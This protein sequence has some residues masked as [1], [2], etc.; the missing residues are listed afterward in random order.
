[1]LIERGFEREMLGGV[2]GGVP[3]RMVLK[4]ARPKGSLPS[5]S[6][7]GHN[8]T[9]PA[10]VLAATVGRT[11]LVGLGSDWISRKLAQDF[12]GKF[13]NI[14][15]IMDCVTCESCKMH[16]RNIRTVPYPPH[17]AT[18][19]VHMFHAAWLNV[20]RTLHAAPRSA[21]ACTAVAG[22]QAKLKAQAIGTALK[23]TLPCTRRSFVTSRVNV[24]AAEHGGYAYLCCPGQRRGRMV[25]VARCSLPFCQSD[26]RC[27]AVLRFFST[28]RTR[29]FRSKG[30]KSSP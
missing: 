14:S 3:K 30:M 19:T 6:Q 26:W 17:A 7:R 24:G 2:Q 28:R 13:N 25:S 4:Q 20:L 10:R 29:R 15:R 5:A 12:R 16:V 22:L 1:V 8:G 11:A 27:A 21:A 18:I 9:G 23:A